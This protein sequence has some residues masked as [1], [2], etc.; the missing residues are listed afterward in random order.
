MLYRLSR[1]T[2]LPLGVDID[3]RPVHGQENVVCISTSRVA[4]VVFVAKTKADIKRINDSRTGTSTTTRLVVGVHV[5][6]NNR[7]YSAGVRTTSQYILREPD[8]YI[9]YWG[10]VDLDTEAGLNLALD[11][12]DAYID[13]E[14][15]H[16]LSPRIAALTEIR[17][18]GSLLIQHF[19]GPDFPSQMKT[20]QYFT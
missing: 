9:S 14:L 7:H 4:G 8:Y 10:L 5:A 18:K 3:I 17:Q 1:R 2:G 13:Q 12:V 16:R 20:W 6:D 11:L 19:R 15:P